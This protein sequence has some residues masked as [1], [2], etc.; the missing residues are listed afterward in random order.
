MARFI[1]RFSIAALL[2]FFFIPASAQLVEKLKAAA[3]EYGI[4]ISGIKPLKPTRVISLASLSDYTR[5]VIVDM[6]ARLKRPIKQS[7]LRA[8]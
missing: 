8:G 4:K 1:K 2:L 7:K 5:F 3:D 6:V